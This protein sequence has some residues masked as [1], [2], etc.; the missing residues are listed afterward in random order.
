MSPTARF[1]LPLFT[2]FAIINILIFSLKSILIK[3]NVDS[4]VLL[5]A[6]AIFLLTNI[7]VFLYQHKALSNPN[8]NVF[9]RSVI[10]GMML[11]MF[12]CAIAVLAYVVIIGK[13]YNKK[14]V[15]ISLFFYLI[16][17]AVEVAILMRLNNKKNA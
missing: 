2:V 15:F 1:L 5:G 16:Y 17:L 10:A 6:N 13:D 8:P 3:F 12:V 4:S 11:K 14:A 7:L 9:I